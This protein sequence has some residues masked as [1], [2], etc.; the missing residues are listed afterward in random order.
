MSRLRLALMIA[1]AAG[2]VQ[3]APKTA[4][5][6]LSPESRSVGAES[7][8]VEAL[9]DP[10]VPPVP[11]PPR[12]PPAPKSAVAATPKPTATPAKTS[13]T[14]AGPFDSR[15]PSSLIAF[16]KTTGASAEIVASRPDKVALA[17][18]TPGGVFGAQYV[19][20][21]PG[22][23]A[24]KALAFTS[25]FERK[26]ANASDINAF[27]R[28]QVLCHAYLGLDGRPN[29]VYSTLVN[30]RMTADEMRL[31]ISAWQGCLATFG[32]FTGDPSGYLAQAR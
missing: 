28:G 1:A 8:G 13:P 26:L 30:L 29:V 5:P 14:K 19:D 4:A 12:K 6:K 20:C 21:A 32:E 11:A 24:C 23:K 22:G 9:P 25:T 31:H 27:N 2:A 10:V 18:T 3:A 17:V 7:L 15:D 16:L